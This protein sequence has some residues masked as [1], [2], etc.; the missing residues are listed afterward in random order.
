[1]KTTCTCLKKWAPSVTTGDLITFNICIKTENSSEEAP[2]VSHP[3]GGF[4]RLSDSD[5][6]IVMLLTRYNGMDEYHILPHIFEDVLFGTS[7]A[8]EPPLLNAIAQVVEGDSRPSLLEILL[9]VTTNLLRLRHLQR[10]QSYQRDD[11]S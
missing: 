11:R 8:A 5:N 1:M 6:P 4:I 9:D 7:L 2:G 3:T 10:E